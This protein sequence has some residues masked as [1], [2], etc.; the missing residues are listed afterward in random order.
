MW[1]VLMMNA[2]RAPL[3]NPT[4]TL[5]RHHRHGTDTTENHGLGCLILIRR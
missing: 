5:L 3:R 1:L 2:T 4:L